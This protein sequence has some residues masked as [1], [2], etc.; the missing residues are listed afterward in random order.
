MRRDPKAFRERFKAWKNGQQVYQGGRPTDLYLD[1]MERVAR[2]NADNWGVSEDEALVHALN[3]N[4]YDYRGYYDKYPESSAD[5]RS[6][7][8]DEFKTVYH[9]TFSNESRYHGK[10]SQYNPYGLRGGTW[11]GDKFQPAPWQS[12]AKAWRINK[13][14]YKDGKDEQELPE[15]FL[16]DTEMP[17]LTV[18][19][20]VE[21]ARRQNNWLTHRGQFPRFYSF[22]NGQGVKE[23]KTPTEKGLEIVSPEFYALAGLRPGGD[24]IAPITKNQ[25]NNIGKIVD[26][27]GYG[28]IKGGASLINAAKNLPQFAKYVWNG[29]KVIQRNIPTK[30]G[31]YYRTVHGR[32]A[33]DD[34]IS[35]GVIRGGK[36]YNQHPYFSKNGLI[37]QPS[38]NS[39]VIEG[40]SETPVQWTSPYKAGTVKT[41][42]EQTI[43][44]FM[45]VENLDNPPIEQLMPVK[46]V[47][48]PTEAIPWSGKTTQVP[49]TGFTYWQKHP[50]I[51]WRNHSFA[52]RGSNTPYASQWDLANAYVDAKAYADS[53]LRV[54]LFEQLKKE[55]ADAGYISQNSLLQLGRMHS[56]KPQIKFEDLGPDVLGKYLSDK[57]QIQLNV[58]DPNPLTPYH[59]YLHSLDVGRPFKD[60]FTLTKKYKHLKR[61]A[62]K[63]GDQEA[64]KEMMRYSDDAYG[65]DD[66]YTHKANQIIESSADPYYKDPLEIDA[67]GLEEGKRLSV[68]IFSPKPHDEVLQLMYQQSLNGPYG[69]FFKHLKVGDNTLDTYWKLLSGQ[70]LP[71]GIG[72]AYLGNKTTK[73][74][75]KTTEKK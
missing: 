11:V 75:N 74:Q 58:T 32:A 33:I 19:G 42:T 20:D 73:Q 48:T 15:G 3:D 38:K 47:I 63:F 39:F 43:P 17:E 62:T 46:D 71:F 30:V 55:A 49:T 18:Y 68:P 4:T 24:I 6:H 26:P 29:G 10:K 23:I 8:T 64:A 56:K 13:L 52:S 27:V 28:L 65:M 14:G 57:H 1:T 31:N 50:I 12:R 53:P 72:A 5:S 40:T 37:V 36:T 61:R 60:S 51:G 44:R 69:H 41:P 59:E 67:Y 34:A 45:Q 9:P 35:T 66:F 2:Q 21:R 54:Q 25:L 70:F 22:G 16:F 7:W